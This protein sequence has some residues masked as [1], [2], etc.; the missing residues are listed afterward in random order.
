MGQYREWLSY[1]DTDQ[2]LQTQIAHLEQE[3]EQ[4]QKQAQNLSE[5]SQ[6]G[7][8]F[9]AQAIDKLLRPF[10]HGGYSLSRDTS[11]QE[12]ANTGLVPSRPP[13]HHKPS[14]LFGMSLLPELDIMPREPSIKPTMLAPLAPTSIEQPTEKIALVK[15]KTPL[16]PRLSL[17]HQ[18]PADWPRDQ[19]SM[20]TNRLIERWAERWSRDE[21]NNT[22][23]DG[24]DA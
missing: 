20:R 21:T 9:I 4:L 23:G 2:K 6:P 22:Q 13:Y 5:Q 8:N 11:T 16:P 12:E 10:A 18:P 19:Q 1:R 14:P 17:A 24:S 3:V 15:R 7:D